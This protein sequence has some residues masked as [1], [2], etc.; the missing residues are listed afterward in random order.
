LPAFL[1]DFYILMSTS[2]NCQTFKFIFTSPTSAQDI[3][4]DK[5]LMDEA[6]RPLKRVKHT[7][8][9]TRGHVAHLLGMKTVT[10]RAIAYIAVQVGLA[11]SKEHIFT[12]TSFQLRYS[13]SN[14]SSWNEN[15]GCFSYST[16]YNNIVDFFEVSVGPAAKAQTRELLSWW[17]RWVYSPSLVSFWRSFTFLHTRKVFGGHSVHALNATRP[18]TSVSKLASQRAARELTHRTPA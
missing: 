9:P 12:H 15:D 6:P 18:G 7:K 16:F 13:L 17:T 5:D 8:A 2:V 3:E 14:A 10:P 4:N 11:L 1:S